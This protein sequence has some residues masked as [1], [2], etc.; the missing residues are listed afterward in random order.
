MVLVLVPVS[1]TNLLKLLEFPNKNNKDVY[2][3]KESPFNHT[4]VYV[5][6]VTFRNLLRMG[7]GC[8]GNKILD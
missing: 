1:C 3:F 2:Y 7:A 8:Q 6:E 4:R 5:N